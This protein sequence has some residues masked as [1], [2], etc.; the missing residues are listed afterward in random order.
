MED[1]GVFIDPQDHLAASCFVPEYEDSVAECRD[2]DRSTL[3]SIRR[4]SDDG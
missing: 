4:G 2:D 3:S 1:G